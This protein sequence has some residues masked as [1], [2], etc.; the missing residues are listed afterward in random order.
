MRIYSDSHNNYGAPKITHILNG[1]GV[2]IS[3]KTVG[4]YMR[5]M[6]IRAQWIRSK[7]KSAAVVTDSE[8]KN[9]LKQ[10][11]NPKSPN[12]AWCSDITYIW[13]TQGFVYLTSVMDL[14]SRMLD[15]S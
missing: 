4:N 12:T 10:N 9:I 2:A 7:P 1:Q 11:F 8:I 6:G 13:T 3:E 14:Y 5:Q 15:I